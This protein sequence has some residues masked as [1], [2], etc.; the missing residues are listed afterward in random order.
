[1]TKTALPHW[2]DVTF[3]YC[4]LVDLSLRLNPDV[5]SKEGERA[6]AYEVTISEKESFEENVIAVSTFIVQSQLEDSP[7]AEVRAKYL[8]SFSSKNDAVHL[9]ELAI[10]IVRLSV[11]PT[12]VSLFKRTVSEAALPFPDLPWT[13][14]KVNIAASNAEV[15]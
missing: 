1:M 6:F 7:E 9:D 15:A 10:Q 13:P 5:I 14:D 4:R 12:F 3:D 2:K 11:W 8:F